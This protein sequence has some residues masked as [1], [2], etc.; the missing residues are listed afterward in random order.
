ME[1]TFWILA[2]ALVES[3]VAK[4]QVGV[5]VDAGV[6]G[7]AILETFLTKKYLVIG[8]RLEITKESQGMSP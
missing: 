3:L 6:V 8:F 1:I 7:V 4:L 5:K 2:D